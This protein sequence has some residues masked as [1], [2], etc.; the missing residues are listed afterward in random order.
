MERGMGEGNEKEGTLIWT[1][2]KPGGDSSNVG[3]AASHLGLTFDPSALHEAAEGGGRFTF[4]SESLDGS[5]GRELPFTR[6]RVGV[7]ASHPGVQPENT[8]FVTWQK[9]NMLNSFKKSHCCIL[10]SHLVIWVYFTKKDLS[11]I[12]VMNIYKCIS[13][14]DVLLIP[15]P[16]R[17]NK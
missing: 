17:I 8:L 12:T 5:G 6:A 3:S 11:E 2:E 14:Y 16:S 9:T 13:I 15:V 4:Q 10:F 1:P 7:G